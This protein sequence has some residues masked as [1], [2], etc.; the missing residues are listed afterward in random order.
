[1]VSEA[2]VQLAMNTLSCSQK[3][4]A[5]QLGVSPT[6][7]S[8][9][10]KG[11]HMSMDMEKKFRQLT[12]IGEKE[13]EF[14]LWAG[15][16]ENADKWDALIHY[17]AETAH[18]GAET[19]YN[20]DPL[21]DEE[22]LLSWDIFRVLHEM[23]V[24]LPKTFPPELEIDKE[25]EEFWDLVE[26]NF[27]SALIKRIFNSLNDVYGF[28]SAFID[29]FMD[30]ESMDLADSVAV[31]IEPC[32]MSLAASKIEVSSKMAPNFLKFKYRVT[33]EY[34]GWIA[35]VKDRAFRAGVPLRA[36]LMD[37]IYKSSSTLGVE[38]EA[39][40]LG[41]NSN[42]IHPDIYMNELLVGMRMIHQVLP[43]I[44]KKLEIYDEFQ[45]DCSELCIGEE[46]SQ[47]VKSAQN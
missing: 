39:E 33:Q 11:E 2:L 21:M 6:Q 27:H 9:W 30:D 24:K 26:D 28:Y 36:E 14:V 25:S 7:I 37:M 8:K 32:L 22:G 18:E 17:L 40:S 29:E 43:V 23:G 42:R 41:F 19:G 47:D 3:Q 5:I 44:M 13:P 4:L 16:I 38:A 31:N 15:S 10:K 20:T 12:A 35:I 45:L 46:R 1:M 34:E